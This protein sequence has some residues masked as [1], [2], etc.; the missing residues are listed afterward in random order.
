[1]KKLVLGFQQFLNESTESESNL[2]KTPA[3]LGFEKWGNGFI[4][5]L[6]TGSKPGD[7]VIRIQADPIATGYNIM[8]LVQGNKRTRSEIKGV[9]TFGEIETLLG[10]KFRRQ[11]EVFDIVGG[12]GDIGKLDKIT[13]KL[14]SLKIDT[15]NNWFTA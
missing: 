2:T 14:K 7:N 11:D 9:G 15:A 5:R 12:Q 1:M 10:S 13:T 8:V 4:L 6:P 3:S